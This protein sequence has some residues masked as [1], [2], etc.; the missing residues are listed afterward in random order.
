MRRGSTPAQPLAPA[1][2]HGSFAARENAPL[3][4]ASKAGLASFAPGMAF[5][6]RVNAVAPGDRGV[7]GVF[8]E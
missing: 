2:E 7:R 5:G 8:I 4:C 3:Y 6:I 1:G